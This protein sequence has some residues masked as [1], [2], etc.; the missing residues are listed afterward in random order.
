MIPGVPGGDF[1]AP[2]GPQGTPG[3]IFCDHRVLYK[4]VV[5]ANF[6][7]AHI[8]ITKTLRKCRFRRLLPHGGVLIRGGRAH[9]ER[10]VNEM[11][12]EPTSIART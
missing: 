3:P 10:L 1:Y 5:L 6:S 2:R 8:A 4:N 7:F 9:A 12:Q 11:I